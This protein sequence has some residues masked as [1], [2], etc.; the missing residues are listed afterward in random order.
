MTGRCRDAARAARRGLN[1]TFVI[2]IPTRR[3]AS[4]ILIQTPGT[5]EPWL[6]ADQDVPPRAA[7]AYPFASRTTTR[8]S[9]R[10]RLASSA[11]R[12]VTT[13]RRWSP[14][15]TDS[16]RRGRPRRRQTISRRWIS[17]PPHSPQN[18]DGRATRLPHLRDRRTTPDRRAPLRAR[19]ERNNVASMPRAAAPCPHWVG[20][21]RSRRDVSPSGR[22]HH[23]AMTTPPVAA[24]A[25]AVTP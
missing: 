12:S 9:T 19:R 8:G 20:V 17:R 5:R 10:S 11:S 22:V 24:P 15:P 7:G 2:Q 6:D 1:D 25:W 4:V 16:P 18:N 23:R 14:T 3:S 21:S 13:S